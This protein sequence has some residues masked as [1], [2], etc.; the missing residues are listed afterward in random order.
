MPF[1]DN[2]NPNLYHTNPTATMTL[3]AP[4]FS[5]WAEPDFRP[6]SIKVLPEPILN[7]TKQYRHAINIV[8]D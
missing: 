8:Q 6:V 5:L 2:N 3:Y 1:P 7:G 4:G